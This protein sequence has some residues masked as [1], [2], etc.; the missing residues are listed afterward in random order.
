MSLLIVEG[1]QWAHL[2]HVV[3]RQVP[4]ALAGDAEGAGGLLHLVRFIPRRLRVFH[5]S[6]LHVLPH[7]VKVLLGLLELADIPERKCTREIRPHTPIKHTN[8]GHI[9]NPNPNPKCHLPTHRSQD[10]GDEMSG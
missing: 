6:D 10:R 1:C 5:L 8:K 9:P 3:Q 7:A 2:E 4:E